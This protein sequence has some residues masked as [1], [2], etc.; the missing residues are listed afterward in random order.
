MAESRICVLIK[1]EELSFRT[2]RHR[3]AALLLEEA[4]ASGKSTAEGLEI[5]LSVT[6]QE[7]AARIG[8]VRELVSRTLGQFESSGLIER[9]GRSIL[10]PDLEALSAVAGRQ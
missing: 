4:Q 7:V 9:R 5:T 10:I 2:V 8:T 1:I 3:L 6:N